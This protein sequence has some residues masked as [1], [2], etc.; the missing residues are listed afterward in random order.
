MSISVDFK[1]VSRLLPI[2]FKSRKPVLLRGK[3]GIGKSEVVYQYADKMASILG[4]EDT[5]YVYPIVER[6]ASQMADAGDLLGLPTLDGETTSFLPMKWFYQACVE[7]CILFL[8]EIDRA[9]SDVRQAIFELTDSRKIAGHTLHKDTVIVSAV[10]GG[11]GES[12]YQVGEMDPAELSRWTVFDLKPSVEDW[13]EY[14][15]DRST[16]EVWNFIRTNHSF[17]EFSGEFE[18]NKVYPSRRSWTRFDEAIA[19]T[20]MLAESSNDLIFLASAY[21][22][23][24]AAVQFHEFVKNYDRMLTVEDV[25]VKGQKDKYSKLEINQHMALIEKFGEHAL[26]KNKLNDVNMQNLVDYLFTIPAELVM[27]LWEVV[28]SANCDNGIAIFEGSSLVNGEK[29]SVSSFVSALTGAV[30]EEEAKK[31]DSK[32]K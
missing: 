19:G 29:K 22:G 9:P 18:P 23:Y 7:P 14:S 16:V 8:D 4:L 5:S 6:R 2:V 32:K 1:T 12:Q 21:V 30:T 26:L 10:N 24:E 31:T 13:L 25:L 11:H 27:K 28:G 15:K 3:H 17:L 20:E